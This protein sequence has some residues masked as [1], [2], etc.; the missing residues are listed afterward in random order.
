MSDTSDQFVMRD[1][2]HG[3]YAKPKKAQARIQ[4]AVALVAIFAN[5]VLAIAF[6]AVGLY[7]VPLLCVAITLSVIAPFFDM[8]SLKSSGKLVYYS[9]L[10]VAERERNGVI[11]IHGGTLLDYVYVIDRSLSGKQRTNQILVGYIDGLLS[12]LR[13]YR[14]YNLKKVTVRGTS[15][16]INE[17]TASRVGLRRVENDFVQSLI[18]V[19]N[20]INVTISYSISR[21]TLSF[22]RIA[23]IGTFEGQ[24]S[25]IAARKELLCNLRDRLSTGLQ[26]A[27]HDGADA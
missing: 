3:F 13:S 17:R 2:E 23:D 4:L 5:L 7:P 26:R 18:L 19:Y 27:R 12:L 15:Y 14:G 6:V 25:D 21:A 11:K 16:I 10:F 22:P 1:S 8:P 24:L 20:Y 9:P